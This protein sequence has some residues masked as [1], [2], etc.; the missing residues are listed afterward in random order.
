MI[1]SGAPTEAVH[2]VPNQSRLRTLVLLLILLAVFGVWWK[3]GMPIPLPQR[4]TAPRYVAPPRPHFP[5]E[6]EWLVGQ[7]GRQIAETAGFAKAGKGP[8]VLRLE[9]KATRQWPTE[10]RPEHYQF[11]T[12]LR[13]TELS[14]MELDLNNYLW[15]PANFTALA[16][17]LLGLPDNASAFPRSAVDLEMFGRLLRPTPDVLIREDKRLSEALTGHPLDAELHEEAALL[18]GSFALRHAAACWYDVRRELTAMT[19]HLAIARAIDKN[20]GPAGELAEAI[21]STLCAR[22]KPALEILEQLNRNR[23]TNAGLPLEANTIWNRALTLRNTGDYR[24][25]DQPEHASLLERLEYVRA[26]RYSISAEA[27]SNFL[28]KFPAERLAEWSNVVLAGTFSVGDGNAWAQRAL[29]DEMAEAATQYRAYHTTRL[30]RNNIVPALNAQVNQIT[31]ADNATARME[32]LGWGMWAQL[33]QRQFCQILNT[34]YYWLDD[35]VGLHDDAREFRAAMTKEFSGLERFPLVG[36]ESERDRADVA[37]NDRRAAKLW[38]EK[39][40]LV[41]FDFWSGTSPRLKRATAKAAPLLQSFVWFQ[42]IFPFGTFYDLTYRAENGLSG[43]SQAQLDQ[44]KSIAPYNNRVI[45]RH[46]LRTWT[47]ASTPEQMNAQFDAV[48]GYD[49]WAMEVVANGSLKDPDRY[50]AIF[51]RLSELNPN[52]Y[53]QLGKYLS[54]HERPEAA[55][56]AYQKAVDLAPDRVHVSN[57]VE[58]LVDYYYDHNRKADAYKVAEMAADVYSARGLA[59]LAKLYERDARLSDA[60]TYFR[61]QAE[62]YE[63][64]EDITLFYTRH[65]NEPKFKAALETVAAKLFQEGRQPVDTV[66]EKTAPTDGVVLVATSKITD[67]LSLAKG[68][69]IVGINGVRIKNKAQ[70]YYQ[71]DTAPSPKVDLT[72]WSHGSYC[73]ATA[74]LPDHRLGAQIRNFQPTEEH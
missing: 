29:V 4:V 24:K 57:V 67:S 46:M 17:Q 53:L 68:D 16:R 18:V 65:P 28:L 39:P 73:L 37:E 40:E 62:R 45:Y 5:T 36:M 15:D 69:V 61:K 19:A 44:A 47:P 34:T 25:L 60:E 11:Q 71:M 58:W 3:Q 20:T 56:R 9:M 64:W 55:A 41:P 43:L 8:A 63:D 26:L 12:K 33:H 72:V 30:E 48:I 27:A 22:Q 32:V 21:L 23:D 51:S 74:D 31:E 6:Q 50:E 1:S 10:E 35:Q 7:I 66:T 14:A 42:P 70:Y 13:G 54:Q 2:P 52:Q 38:Q 59:T 49:V